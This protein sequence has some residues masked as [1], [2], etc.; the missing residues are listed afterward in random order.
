LFT[1][2]LTNEGFYVWIDRHSKLR[3]SQR[4]WGLYLSRT[5]LP[6]VYASFGT[7]LT[8]TFFS[9]SILLSTMPM[10]SL[11]LLDTTSMVIL[12]LFTISILIL[13]NFLAIG[14]P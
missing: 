11:I 3:N 8:G 9:I 14:A 7:A 10:V 2:G 5:G 13:L 1:S 4:A 6:P 12:I